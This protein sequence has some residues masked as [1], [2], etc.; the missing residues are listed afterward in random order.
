ML[1]AERGHSLDRASWTRSCAWVDRPMGELAAPSLLD[2]LLALEPLDS[3]RWMHDGHLDAVAVAFA[4]VVDT[5]TPRMG[6]HGRRCRVRGRTGPSWASTTPSSRASAGGPAARYRQAAGAIAT[7]RSPR[8]S[9]K[10]SDTWSMNTPGQRR[11][12]CPFAAFAPLAP[13]VVAITSAGRRHVRQLPTNAS[14]PD[15]VALSDRYE[16]MTAEEP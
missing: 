9:R 6:R 11:R 12:P 13:L 5:R 3:I 10:P 4:D 14:L 2:R 1:R 15:V 7:W 8:N 16:A